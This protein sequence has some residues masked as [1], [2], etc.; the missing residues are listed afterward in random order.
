M[1]LDIGQLG[2]LLQVT[3]EYSNAVLVAMLP[4]VSNVAQKLELP[5]P[6]PI[7]RQH[8]VGCGIL[9]YIYNNGDWAGCGI[10][11]EGGWRFGFHWGYM[12]HFESPHS[13]FALQDPRKIPQFFGTVRMNR[14]EAVQM[15]RDT[16]HKLG[17]PLDAVFA[18]QAP[19]VTMPVRV[20]TNTVP[21]YRVQ[22]LD[23][24]VDS[25]ATEIEINGDAKCVEQ[26]AI[27][28]NASL[29]RSW[30]KF[31][32]TPL[33][34]SKP[35]AANPA[36]CMK[37]LPIVLNGIDKYGQAL[38]LSLP[39][40]LATNHIARFEVSDNG[41]W[42]H[43]EVE[44]TNGWRF[45]FRNSA[46]NGFY[47]PDN[48]FASDNRPIRIEEFTGKSKVSEAKAIDLVRKALARLRYPT[49]LV[50]MDFKPKIVKPTVAGIPRV[51]FCWNLENGE[52]DDLISKIEAEVDMEKG[53]IKS[54]YFD[55]KALW[56]H[57]PAIDV[58]IAPPRQQATRDGVPARRNRPPVAG[59]PR[60]ERLVPET[61]SPR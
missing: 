54:L 53:E 40:P 5:V 49:N 9:P 2:G 60:R 57:P 13:Y 34:R 7:T 21:Y 29:S 4:C 18:D 39:H 23:P 48:F 61:T 10:E 43:S 41:G 59:S 31:S 16:L 52:G 19:R 55:N 44:L 12:D 33:V 15:A 47:A 24:R 32:V 27:K 56:N 11:I 26:I 30:P 3:A 51:M 1:I 14:D 45:V 17:I 35:L 20:Q 38:G 25:V 37:L 42:P 28:H 46:V 8:V 6:Q 36:Y 50:R 22:W 58:P